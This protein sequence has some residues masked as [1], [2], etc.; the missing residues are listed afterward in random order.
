MAN[1]YLLGNFAPVLEERTESHP[2]PVTGV[3]PPDLDGSFLRNGPNPA[4]RP[5]DETQY[6]WFAGDG[7]LHEITVRAGRAIGYRNRWVRTRRLATELGTEPPDGPAEPID[8]PANAHIVRHAGTTLALSGFGAPLA[9]PPALDRARVHDFDGMLASPMTTHPKVDPD[10]GELVFFG[11][12]PFGPP[13]LRYHVANESGWLT[14]NEEIDLPS[15]VLMHDF[16]VT[17]TRVVFLDLPVLFDL[18]MV[19]QSPGVPYRWMT[20]MP[21][22]VGL[23]PRRGTGAD[24]RWLSIDPVFVLHVMNAFDDGDSV[25]LDVICYDTAFDTAPGEGIAS[26]LP[27]LA[28]WTLDPVRGTV[29]QQQLDDRPVEYPRIDELVAGRPHRSGYCTILADDPHRPEPVGLVHYDLLRD[30]SVR[31]DPGPDRYPGEAVFVRAADGK[32]EG[33]G[34]ILTLV[35]DATRDA[36]DLVILDAT[37]FAGPPVASVHLPYRVPFGAH[38]SWI[39]TGS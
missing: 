15:A 3:I 12:D 28:R 21:A 31:F 2:L 13:F 30:E 1:P 16:G 19:G 4:V 20:D 39:P 5:E 6:H 38:G 34:W 9:V 11:V 36:S 25:V 27:Y 24:V 33:E 18:E 22:R 29:R 35:Y 10:S 23:L 37:S 14:V 32:A 17:A 26:S 7:M 8:G